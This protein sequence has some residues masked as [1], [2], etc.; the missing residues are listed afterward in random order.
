VYRYAGPADAASSAVLPFSVFGAYRAPAR[1]RGMG[2]TLQQANPQAGA[3]AAVAASAATS[4][5]GTL[6]ALGTVTGP[7]GAAIAGLVAAAYAIANLFGGCGETCVE[8]T[9]LANQAA[10]IIDQ[11]YTQYMNAP[12]H[13]ASMQTAYLQLFDGTW[14]ALVKACSNPALGA[15]GQRC[16]SDRQAGS[17]A[18]KTS[19][20]GW[21]QSS[22]G[23]WA[24]IEPGLNGSGSA[25]WNSF[26]GRRD[27]VANDP[28]VVPD[29]G[30]VSSLLSS[31]TGGGSIMGVPAPLAIGGLALLGLA[32]WAS[33]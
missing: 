29:P 22:D 4:V 2:A 8:A 5:V 9:N 24:Y 28:T 31:V 33:E 13:Y 16:I 18:Y 10:S 12:V 19:P 7:V 25:C 15:A 27:P 32:W 23:S 17:C 14:S 3:I 26:I 20:G 6:V 11:A 21:K 30:G 1:R